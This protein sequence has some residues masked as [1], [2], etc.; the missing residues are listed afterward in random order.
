MKYRVRY[1]IMC[2]Y[3]TKEGTNMIAKQLCFPPDSY[4]F[5]KRVSSFVRMTK[6]L[7]YIGMHIIDCGYIDKYNADITF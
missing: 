2:L 6:L 1:V 5:I 7:I 3:V 4:N